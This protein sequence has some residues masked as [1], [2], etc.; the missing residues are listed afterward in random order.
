MR[1]FSILPVV[2]LLTLPLALTAQEAPDSARAVESFDRAWSI[3]D[4]TYFDT[5]FAGLDWPAIRDELRPQVVASPD[6]ATVR[7]VLS[8]MLDR[9]GQ[10]HFSLIPSE[11]ADSLNP[12]EEDVSG[13]IGYVGLDVRL[14]GDQVVVTKV[15]ANGSAAEAG[16]RPGWIVAAIDED[17]MD[18]LITRVRSADTRRHVTSMVWGSVQRR[19][20]GEPGT[21]CRIEFLTG[22]DEPVSLTLTR[23]PTP[24]E[25]V[26]FGNLPTLFARFDA[27]VVPTPTGGRVGIMWFNYWMA[28]LLRELDAAVDEYRSADGLVIDL[29]GNGGGLG[30]MVMGVAGHLLND[31]VTLGTM[32]TRSGDL[33]F[34][35]NPRRVNQAAEAVTPYDGPVAI[36]I[37]RLS[38]S[39]SEVFA[40]GLQAI[41]RVRVFGDTSAGAVL[42]ATMDR[43]PNRDVLYHAIGDFETADGI[44]L[45]GRGVYPD[46]P[47]VLDRAAL[48]SGKDPVLEAALE[49]IAAYSAAGSR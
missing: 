28:P 8:E 26:K 12:E 43:L 32:K 9:F 30:G 7:R 3:I 24:D 33:Q 47:V 20:Q 6:R 48:L 46:E 49:W 21:D 16:V 41:D 23:V 22:S 39:A 4:A 11:V 37:D 25:P 38:G 42:P 17:R 35:A 34:R 44:R 13:A 40:G 36:L 15:D 29:R 31:K 10:S 18:D 14:L 2:C 5:T 45:E 1:R 27:S 19:L